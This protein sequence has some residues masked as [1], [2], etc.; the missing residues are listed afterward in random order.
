MPTK[1]I[2]EDQLE[3][4][5][6][7]EMLDGLAGVGVETGRL[8]LKR[9][10][11][12]THKTAYIACSMANA[13]GGIIALGLE[14]PNGTDPLRVHPGLDVSD[15]TKAALISGI[16]ARVYPPI[17]ID[18]HGYQNEDRS[19]SFLVLRI[20][21]SDLAPHE[22]TGSDE[23]HNLPVRRGTTTD[24]LRLA[25]IDGLRASRSE[26][27]ESPLGLDS[28]FRRIYL[29]SEGMNPDCIFG[30]TI[31][32]VFYHSVRRV[33]DVEDDQLCNGVAE[34]TRGTDESLHEKLQLD[35]LIDGDWLH[36]P[37]RTQADAIGGRIP[38]PEHQLEIRSDGSI[39]VR[40]FQREG[41][42]FH[43]LFAVLAIGY[44]AAQEIFYAFDLSP[45]ARIHLV[46]RLSAAAQE[47]HVAQS[48]EDYFPA[49]LAT[50][51][52]ADAFLGTTT[53]ILRGAN[54][55][56]AREVVRNDMLQAFVDKYIPIADELQTRW[57]TQ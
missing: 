34:E 15:R 51:P 22:Y 8:E 38:Q 12:S 16:N 33:M 11:I 36:T 26:L 3:A 56:S 47:Q 28:S 35:T 25:E 52:F 42:L 46:L 31:H 27:Q 5:S 45:Q 37:E 41:N 14:E 19:Q 40:F 49:D 53:L 30:M 18:I 10:R 48:F 24:H 29:A 54:Q 21:R 32:P 57:L 6:F 55:N 39:A 43:Q 17:P 20:G 4:F 50:Q 23:A 9:E 13:D 7:Q 44:V 2:Y 1:N